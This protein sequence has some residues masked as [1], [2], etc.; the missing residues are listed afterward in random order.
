VLNASQYSGTLAAKFLT[1]HAGGGV[2]HIAFSTNNIFNTL[3]VWQQN[4]VEL[5]G[6]SE[7]YYADLE[8]RFDFD[9]VLLER[10]RRFGVLYDRTTEGEFFHAYTKTIADL[11]F[12]E[13]CQRSNYQGYGALNAAVR[14]AAQTR[15]TDSMG[16]E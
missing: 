6:I 2:Q 14:I 10:M 12:F 5:L 7:N 11:F 15:V 13:I 9:P 3:E 16:D 1:E 8:A 4:G